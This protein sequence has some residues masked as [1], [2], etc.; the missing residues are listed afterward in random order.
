[1]N[2]QFV[3]LT[4]LALHNIR[5]E[6]QGEYIYG[7]LLSIA[8]TTVIS[9]E[10]VR[11]WMIVSRK[12]VDLEKLK[13]EH[14]EQSMIRQYWTRH[15]DEQAQKHGDTYMVRDRLRWTV[16]QVAL[17]GL[18]M[19]SALQISLI[20]VVQILYVILIMKESKEKQVFKNL[21]TKIQY[22]CQESAILTFLLV[23]TLFSYL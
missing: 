6:T 7:Y 18:Q 19:N 21:G 15:L 16:F 13:E 14:H 12:N 2:L 5:E 17:V 22:I 20:A 10:F 1:M 23:L 8:V 9:L 4:Q 3:S 11:A